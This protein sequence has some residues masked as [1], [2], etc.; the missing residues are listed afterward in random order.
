MDVK[1][2]SKPAI[3]KYMN[4]NLFFNDDKLKKYYLRDEA[5]DLGK[6]RK[7]IK[8]KFSTKSFDKFVYVCV[9]DITRDIILTTIGELGEFMKVWG[10]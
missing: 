3:D 10:T 4:D 2:Y 5:R 8:D 9:T 6:F 7:R 1:L